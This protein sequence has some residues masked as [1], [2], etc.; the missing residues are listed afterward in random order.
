MTRGAEGAEAKLQARTSSE[1]IEGRLG[2]ATCPRTGKPMTSLRQERPVEVRAPGGDFGG[3]QRQCRRGDPA[4]PRRVPSS[5]HIRRRARYL[6]WPVVQVWPGRRIGGGRVGD[7]ITHRERQ[8][9]ALRGVRWLVG[10]QGGVMPADPSP[11]RGR[12]ARMSERASGVRRRGRPRPSS[13][14]SPVTWEHRDQP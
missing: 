8:T 7:A 6:G 2:A 10:V 12:A 5:P 9:D 4:I 1:P 3:P 14:A 11:P 13:K